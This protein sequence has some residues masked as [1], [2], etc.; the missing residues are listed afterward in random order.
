[1][2]ASVMLQAQSDNPVLLTIDDEPVYQSDFYYIY[3]KN[4]SST[5]LDKKSIAEYMDLFINFKLKVAEAKAQ[6]VDTTETFKKELAGYRK[7]ITTPY[8]VDAAAEEKLIATTYNQMQEE[9]E[10]SHIVVRCPLN[11]S[12]ADTLEAYSKIMAART[13]V[14]VGIAATGKT[15]RRPTPVPEPFDKVA[16]D[17]SEDPSVGE[18]GGYVGWVT[19]FRFVYPFEK[20]VYNTP[21]GEVTM[22]FRSPFGYHIA[23]V[24]DVRP[25]Q[26][27][28]ASHIMLFAQPGVEEANA[29]AKQRIDSIYK[30]VLAGDDFASL[31]MRHSQ[32]QGT[33]SKGGELPW[34]GTGRMVAPFEKAAFALK[35]AGD[36]SEPILSPYGWHIIKLHNRRSGKSFEEAKEE[37]KRNIQHDERGKLLK[38]AFVQQLKG[39]YN[40]TANTEQLAA[41]TAL[42]TQ[43]ALSD[44]LFAAKA[45]TMQAP[46]FTFA[47]QTRTQA[48]FGSYLVQNSHSAYTIPSLIVQEKFTDYCANE[49]LSYEDSQLESKYPDFRQLVQEYHDGILLFEV[50]LREVW[51]RASQDVEGI[52]AFF[53]AN[54]ENYA[55][56][57]PHYKGRVVACRDKNT[58]KAAKSIVKK[59]PA[60][61]I[62]TYLNRRLNDSIQYVKVEKGLYVK[63][64][65]PTVDALVFKTGKVEPTEEY[66]YLFVDGKLLKRYPESYTD[67]RGAVVTDYQE[68]LEQEW[69]KTL[70]QKHTVWINEPLFEQMQQEQE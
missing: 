28:L 60:D 31:A 6:G 36:V 61:S 22:P 45:E 59:S 49:L 29:T 58:L 67:V 66:P 54:K 4:N 8:L 33:A 15:V 48:D 21:V 18:N 14:T 50:S 2:L 41:I 3:K 23:K 70:R 10:V 25:S 55:W 63:G 65:N 40:F 64:D 12:A 1:M 5:M 11:A 57:E 13:R 52:T 68:Y 62:D 7:Q 37:I 27:V 17:V 51:D 32:D 46:L 42:A 43:H 69:I 39:Q 19:P 26:E 47:D 16:R 35:N 34:F 44:S 24:T 38:T 56:S 20:A 53:N 30:R 9:R